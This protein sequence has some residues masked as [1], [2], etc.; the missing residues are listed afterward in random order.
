MNCV[1]CCMNWGRSCH[2]VAAKVFGGE[3]AKV[4]G[5]L[6]LTVIE[7][8]RNQLTHIES[9]DDDIAE[10]E[11][12]LAAWKKN[13]VATQRLMDIPGVGLL[14]ATAAVATIGDPKTFKPDR[15]F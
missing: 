14:G 3:L 10:I 1:D 12:K 9:L 2:A 6:P 4:E 7:L 5:V 13:D 11:K 15:Q 8:M